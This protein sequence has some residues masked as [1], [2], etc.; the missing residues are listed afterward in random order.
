RR[1]DVFVHYHEYTSKE[2]YEKGMITTRYFHRLEKKL[3]AEVE[4][5]SHTNDVRMQL[6]L[7]DNALIQISATHILPNYPPL[8]WNTTRENQKISPLKIVYV[9]SLGM[10]SMFIK[11]FASWLVRQEGEV[12]WDIYSI[13]G[14]EDV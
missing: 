3:Y 9:G 7:E 1:S 13:G 6:F 10:R 11:E 5:L 4:W 2:E 14:D 12:V 8:S